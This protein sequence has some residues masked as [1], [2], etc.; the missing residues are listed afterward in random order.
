MVSLD[1]QRCE[2]ESMLEDDEATA[3]WAS[4]LKHHFLTFCIFCEINVSK[5]GSFREK[6]CVWCQQLNPWECHGCC[7][8]DK[9][10]YVK[11]RSLLTQSSSFFTCTSTS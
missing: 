4:S 5:Q 6:T 10:I 2:S 9:I 8:A 7:S 1:S 11:G 3:M